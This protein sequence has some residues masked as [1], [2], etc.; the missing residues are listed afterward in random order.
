MALKDPLNVVLSDAIWVKFIVAEPV[1][2]VSAMS[3]L[4]NYET[5][6]RGQ[7]VLFKDG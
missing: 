5:L 7:L 2:C 3:Y 1:D 6:E 4:P